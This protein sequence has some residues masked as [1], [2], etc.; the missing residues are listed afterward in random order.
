MTVPPVVVVG[1]CVRVCCLSKRL[2]MTEPGCR[3]I[4]SL[5]CYPLEQLLLLLF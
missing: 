4:L 2:L 3:A 1:V 5:S